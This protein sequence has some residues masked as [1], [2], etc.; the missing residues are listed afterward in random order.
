MLDAPVT[1]GLLPT[2]GPAEAPRGRVGQRLGGS[3]RCRFGAIIA[4]ARDSSDSVVCEA[5]QQHGY[6]VTCI[7]SMQS[8]GSTSAL[9]DAKLESE[10]L[11]VATLF[12]EAGERSAAGGTRVVLTVDGPLPSRCRLGARSCTLLNFQTRLAA[13]RRKARGRPRFTRSRSVLQKLLR[14]RLEV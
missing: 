10:A 2:S 11:P 12:N 14:R 1:Y 6:P 5:P 7:L 8:P 3:V 4:D 13:T 9:Y